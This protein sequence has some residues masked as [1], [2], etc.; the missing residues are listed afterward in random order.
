MV[1][2]RE[3]RTDHHHAA[4]SP[5]FVIVH[6]FWEHGSDCLAGEE[7]V[8]VWLDVDGQE[9]QLRLPLALRLLFDHL[10]KHRWVAQS[11]TQIEAAMRDD[12]FYVRHATNSRT[13]R[14][15]TRRMSRSG[16]KVYV[17]RIRQALQ[18]AFDEGRVDLK[19]T[20]VLVSERTVSNEV[21]YRLRGSV[22][23][24]HLP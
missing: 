9:V 4:W 19:A 15:L 2:F 12:I 22:R 24:V 5:G 10:G 3:T 1:S 7:I 17:A 21:G 14:K 16:I 6:R 11:A 18:F 20:E 23:W 13:S 8:G